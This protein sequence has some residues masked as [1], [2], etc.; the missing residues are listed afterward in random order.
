MICRQIRAEFLLMYNKRTTFAVSLEDL[1]QYIDVFVKIPS[2]AN[3]DVVGSLVVSGERTGTTPINLESLMRLANKARALLIKW[4]SNTGIASYDL[5]PIFNAFLHLDDHPILLEYISASIT[6][7]E[8]RNVLGNL[9]IRLSV[10]DA[11]WEGWMEY[12][13]QMSEEEGYPAGEDEYIEEYEP[14]IGDWPD[15]NSL[16]D[17][18]KGWA[19]AVHLSVPQPEVPF[20]VG[21][22]PA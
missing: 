4:Y 20:F 10:K 17:A 3:E 21:F 14:E 7:I 1:N 22:I 12:T 15:R 13:A 19:A 11:S 9:K 2:V 5:N 18:L 6:K 8:A 16:F